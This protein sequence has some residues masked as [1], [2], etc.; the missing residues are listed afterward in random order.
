METW[1]YQ[2]NQ[3]DNSTKES[4]VLML[5]L[6]NDHTAKLMAQ[7]A[8]PEIDALFTRTAP[9][10][11]AY[12]TGYSTWKSAV[13]TRMGGTLRVE[14]LLA[15]LSGTRIKQWDIQIQGV[16]IEGTPDYTVLLPNRRGPF[17]NGTIDER[18]NEVQ[19]LGTRLADY[20][21][22]AAT[23][24]NV[25]AFYTTLR[26]ARDN[27]QLLEQRIAQSSSELELARLAVARIMY[28]NV[29]VLMNKYRDT[30]EF[31]GN[32]WEVSLMQS[33]KTS[34]SFNGTVDAGATA[35]I[36]GTVGPNAKVVVTNTGL[37]TL[38]FCLAAAAPDACMAG[39]KVLPGQTLKLTRADLGDAAS[40]FLNVTNPSADTIGSYEVEVVG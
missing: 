15:E 40:A 11:A 25:D 33:G 38:H 22:L 5:I 2:N 32:F 21:A 36:T 3:F 19:G 4:F 27:Q 34:R 17:Q 35:N 16:H 26:S 10:D 39:V 7:A 6:S 1:P 13:G 12:T 23:K 30:P 18:I 14:Q 31:V 28:G 8:D 9:L 37:T 20:P 24:T 29:G